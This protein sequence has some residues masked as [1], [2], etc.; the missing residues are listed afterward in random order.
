MISPGGP[1]TLLRLASRLVPVLA[2]LATASIA[3]APAFADGVTTPGALQ[4]TQISGGPVVVNQPT[5]FTIS[6]T[7]TTARVA[8]GVTLG[9]A[10]PAGMA[11]SNLLGP[12]GNPDLCARTRGGGGV[13]GFACV[14]GD[15][16]PSASATLSFTG[17]ATVVGRAINSAVAQGCTGLQA[18]LPAG[19]PCATAGGVFVTTASPLTLQVLA[20][21][22]APT[23]A[24]VPAAPTAVHA[25]AD[26]AQAAVS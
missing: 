17:T 24:T 19:L 14:M 9:D 23:P 21:A 11:I 25:T 12:G 5:S 3:A 8:G 16:A 15:L 6:V 26:N 2:M 22:P 4:V 1:R 20:T 13:T 18:P 10:L 7:N